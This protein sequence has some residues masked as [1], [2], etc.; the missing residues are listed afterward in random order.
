[1]KKLLRILGFLFLFLVL[2][3]AAGLLYFNSAYPVKI[4]VDDFQIE[5]TPERI[6]RGEYLAHHVTG[7]IDCHSD[8]NFEFYAG[9]IVDGTFG[10][11]GTAFDE[12]LADV[13]GV[14]YAKNITPSGIGNWS[15]GEL[16]RAIVSGID[17]NNEALFPLMPYTHF[18]GMA[19]EDILSIMA[20]IRTLPAIENKIPER[21]LKFPVNFIVKTIPAP[22]STLASIPDKSNSV[23][24]G[25]YMINAAACIHCHTK[26]VQGEFLPG[27]EFAGGFRFKMPNGDEIY[28]SNITPDNETGIGLMSKEAFIGKFKAFV[29]SASGQVM[30]PVQ[31][32]QKNTIMPWTK[33]G[34]MTVEDLGA[35]YEYL[36]TVPPV[37]HKVTTFIP[38]G[39]NI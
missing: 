30:I 15:N 7:C 9:P 28:S 1:M 24:Y 21:E 13:P 32:H 4:S 11:G 35:I 27:M 33:L 3:A 25:K 6:A 38:A 14:I 36:R 37:N 19:K 34:G 17:K 39:K 20:Y 10:K 12:A 26:A 31:E 16:Y 22:A 18:A 8:R 5:S 29:D 2:A 23:E